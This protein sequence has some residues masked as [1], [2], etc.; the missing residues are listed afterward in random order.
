MC[1]TSI[2]RWNARLA[3]APG[4]QTRGEHQVSAPEQPSLARRLSSFIRECDKFPRENDCTAYTRDASAIARRGQAAHGT[5][6]GWFPRGPTSS[7]GSKVSNNKVE[8][9]GL[10]FGISK[11]THEAIVKQDLN[12]GPTVSWSNTTP[13]L[14]RLLAKESLPVHPAR[15]P[16]SPAHHATYSNTSDALAYDTDESCAEVHCDDCAYFRNLRDILGALL[17]VF[18]LAI[19]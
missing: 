3:S 12:M 10:L 9:E 4:G 8:K 19:A 2:R 13:L 18:S 7:Y 15:G 16:S 5:K 17:W 1:S 14:H 6:H 11:E